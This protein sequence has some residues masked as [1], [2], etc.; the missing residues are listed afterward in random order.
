M[1]VGMTVVGSGVG[2]G[3]LWRVETGA[4]REVW[5][6]RCCLF[7]PWRDGGMGGRLGSVMSTLRRGVREGGVLESE[8]SGV[9]SDFVVIDACSYTRAN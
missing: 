4:C 7:G 9:Q 6:M 8:C 3:E 5:G 1:R 2:A